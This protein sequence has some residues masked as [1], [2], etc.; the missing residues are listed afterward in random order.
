MLHETPSLGMLGLS[1]P[2][3]SIVLGIGVAFWA[4]YWDYRTRQLKYRERELMIEKGMTPPPLL[5][6]KMPA[7]PEDY[8]RRGIILAFLG[9]GLGIGYFILVGLSGRF[10]GV[11]AWMCAIGGA[12]VGFLGVGFLVYYAIARKHPREGSDKMGNINI[13]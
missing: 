8:L 5:P 9:I 3:L 7:S 4:I 10:P 13:S 6:D 12:I 2:I 1:I 11:P